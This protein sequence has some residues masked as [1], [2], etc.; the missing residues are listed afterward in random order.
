MKKKVTFIVHDDNT[1]KLH[2]IQWLLPLKK[3]EPGE[4]STVSEALVAEALEEMVEKYDFLHHEA[5]LFPGIGDR[6]LA[7][8][9]VTHVLYISGTDI[10]SATLT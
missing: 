4:D 8:Y 9:S 6:R 5:F 3:G 2:M 7:N 1:N 10:K